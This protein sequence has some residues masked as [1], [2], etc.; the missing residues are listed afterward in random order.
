M[1]ISHSLGLQM[2]DQK[3]QGVHFLLLILLAFTWGSSFILM[4][5]G[6]F[7]TT[8]EPLFTSWEI[9]AMRIAIAG[10]VLAPWAM[11]TVRDIPRRQLIWVFL[12]G[13]IGNAIPAFL[14][15]AAQTRLA[16][17]FAGMLNSLVPLFT[18]VI[19][20][21]VFRVRYKAVQIIGL[22][23]GLAGA[24]GLIQAGQ[25]SGDFHLQSALLVVLA[26]FC[27][28]TSVNIIRNK[29]GNVPS[30]SL[31]A[32]SLLMVAIPNMLWLLSRDIIA[33]TL[34][35][36]DGMIGMVSVIGLAAIGTAAAVVVFNGLIKQT[37]A[38][39]ASSVTYVIP[40]FAT[41]W[42]WVDGETLSWVHLLFAAVIISGVYLVNAG[43]ARVAS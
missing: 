11:R 38:I 4:K 15:T 42:G 21:A 41:L 26:T 1:L 20:M 29:L 37:S 35:R 10:L 22:L 43:K 36:E 14:F 39:F 5:I 13:L 23:I 16:S 6:L 7:G 8:G 24:I 3:P 28:A 34:E 32:T 18:L 25:G 17:S 30:V 19:A 2:S 27:Y 33:T 12:V 40:V 31:A 9:G